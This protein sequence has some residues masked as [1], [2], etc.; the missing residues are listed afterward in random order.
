M[1]HKW[2]DKRTRRSFVLEENGALSE[3]GGAGEPPQEGEVPEFVAQEM[4]RLADENKALKAALRE[5]AHAVDELG[6]DLDFSYRKSAEWEA[7][8]EG[9]HVTAPGPDESPR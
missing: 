6:E 1:E 5:A 9:E 2:T 8:L 7:L 4:L 3:A